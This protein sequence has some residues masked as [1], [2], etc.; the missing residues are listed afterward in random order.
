[1]LKLN[2]DVDL[3][4]TPTKNNKNDAI[5]ITN[6]FFDKIKMKQNKTSIIKR[7]YKNQIGVTKKFLSTLV[8]PVNVPTSFWQNSLSDKW[9]ISNITTKGIPQI[10]PIH[11]A[12]MINL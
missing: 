6:L 11:Q 7:Q 10:M 8:A 12:G 1:M 9:P 2:N 4:H 3:K 5:V